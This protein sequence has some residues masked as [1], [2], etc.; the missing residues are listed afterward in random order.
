MCLF[1]KVVDGCGWVAF[2]KFET[3]QKMQH[4]DM[5]VEI[6]AMKGDK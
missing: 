6:Q 5:N 3:S 1:G 4:V 2:F